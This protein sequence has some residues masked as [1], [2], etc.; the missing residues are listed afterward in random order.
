MIGPYRIQA[1]HSYIVCLH[2]YLAPFANS[3]DRCPFS[4][5]IENCSREYLCAFKN[6]L[7]LEV[8]ATGIVPP[9]TEV[10]GASL[11]NEAHLRMSPFKESSP[12]RWAEN[13]NCFGVG[14]THLL[15]R[16]VKTFSRTGRESLYCFRRR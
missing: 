10:R 8:P 15:R 2:P 9:A 7:C 14:S 16:E 5:E 4:G 13:Q 3:Q 12:S 6:C 1:S 11:R